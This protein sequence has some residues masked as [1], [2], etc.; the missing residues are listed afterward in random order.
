MKSRH[1]APL[2]AAFTVLV[3]AGAPVAA[4]AGGQGGSGYGV[5]GPTGVGGVV[6]AYGG[7]TTTLAPSPDPAPSSTP[8]DYYEDIPCTECALSG[9]VCLASGKLSLIPLPPN[10]NPLTDPL[11][12]GDSVPMYVE[13]ISSTTG[14]VLGYAGETLCNPTPPPVPPSAADVWQVVPLPLPQLEFNPSSYGLAQL[15]TWFWL[16][17]D[18]A[19]TDVTVGPLRIDGYSVTVTAH[20]VAYYWSF[21][22]GQTAVS[23]TAGSSGSAANASTTHTYV[24]MGTFPVGVIVAW[25]GSYTFT[26]F[27][28]TETVA[29]G[30]VDQ[31]EAFQPYVVQEVRSVLVG[32]G[33]QS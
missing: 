28:V 6:G 29:L 2:V 31:A 21:G 27:G 1:C 14:Q 19:G 30:P 15:P 16:N 7:P 11:P 23:D 22:D 32:G 8:P 13:I 5:V 33:S 9:E 25:V 18:P 17:D 24:D 26:G 12:A 4:Y 10:F 3:M 20:P